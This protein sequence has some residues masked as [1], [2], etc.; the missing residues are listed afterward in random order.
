MLSDSDLSVPVMYEA[1]RYGMMGEGM[2]GY[3][4]VLIDG[5]GKVL[6]HADYGG[7]PNYSMFILKAN[8]QQGLKVARAT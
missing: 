1:N 2:D 6:W 5:K 8:I 7:A 4:F 3:S